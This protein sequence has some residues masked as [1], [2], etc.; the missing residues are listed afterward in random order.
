MLCWKLVEF[1]AYVH[2]KISQYRL[3]CNADNYYRQPCKSFCFVFQLGMQK[4][5]HSLH[6]VQKEPKFFFSFFQTTP[7]FATISSH[8]V[9][10]VTHKEHALQKHGKTLTPACSCMCVRGRIV[11]GWQRHFCSK[12]TSAPCKCA[13]AQWDKALGGTKGTITSH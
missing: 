7:R 3:Q 1:P 2:K 10:N 4:G 9:S 11:L 6:S 12:R 13:P 5:L 8:C